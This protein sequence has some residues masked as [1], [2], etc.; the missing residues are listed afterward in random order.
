MAIKFSKTKNNYK[1]NVFGKKLICVKIIGILTRWFS[2]FHF[3]EVASNTKIKIIPS[4]V[5]FYLIVKNLPQ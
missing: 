4:L 3:F 2:F 5:I 1:Y